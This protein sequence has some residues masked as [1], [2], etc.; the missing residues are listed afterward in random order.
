MEKV[1]LG[2][3]IKGNGLFKDGDW[4]ESKDQDLNGDV[5]LIQLA[6]IGIRNFINKSNRF[7]NYE[8]ALELK[9]TFLEKGDILIARMPDPIGRCCE[10][11]FE[12]INKYVTVVDIAIFRNKNNDLNNRYLVHY[13]NSDCFLNKVSSGVTGTTRQRISR[14]KLEDIQIP[15]PS[16][17]EQKAIAEKLDKAQEIIR[18]NEEIIAQYDALTQSL[19]LDMFGDPVKNEKGWEKKELK[20]F[21]NISTGNTPSRTDLENYSDNY[22]EWIKT[23]NIKADSVVITNASEFLSYKGAQKGRIVRKG[24]LLVACIAGSIDSIGRCALTDRDVSFNQ[25]INAIQP[26]EN[27]NSLF[28]Y[29]LIKNNSKYIQGFASNGMKRMLSKGEFQKI[30]FISPPIE[31]QNL[32]AERVSAIEAQKQLAQKSLAKSQ[33]LFGS[34]LQESFKN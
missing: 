16:L 6:D 13:I 31:L 15:L 3:L 28:L 23:D 17:S 32:F 21:G 30:I 29:C 25:Q 10:F 4:I 8:K 14:K 20:E 18:Y 22:I 11:P 12:D 7:M 24:A 9:C 19:F 5:R 2:D 26:N 1:R 33:A 27:I 34:L